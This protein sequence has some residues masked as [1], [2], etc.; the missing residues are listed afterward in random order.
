MRK[1]SKSAAIWI[2]L[3]ILLTAVFTVGFIS[4]RDPTAFQ[5]RYRVDATL[6]FVLNICRSIWLPAGIIGIPLFLVS[7]ILD[8]RRESKRNRQE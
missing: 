8:L 3:G 1:D 4:S 2:F 6:D 5:S 7:L